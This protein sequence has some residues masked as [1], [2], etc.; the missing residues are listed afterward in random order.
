[1][2]PSLFEHPH[3]SYREAFVLAKRYRC[4][5]DAETKADAYR[6]LSMWYPEFPEP[7]IKKSLEDLKKAFEDLRYAE[8]LRY[9]LRMKV[10]DDCRTYLDMAMTDPRSEIAKESLWFWS[11]LLFDVMKKDADR[12]ARNHDLSP[13]FSGPC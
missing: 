4:E 11:A 12:I 8:D 13:D 9:T 2:D 7:N 3:I 1:M 5:T 10:Y 6:R